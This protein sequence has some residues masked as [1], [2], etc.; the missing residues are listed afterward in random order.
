M[1]LPRPALRQR[2]DGPSEE[3]YELEAKCVPQVHS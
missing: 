2:P 3:H 1:A